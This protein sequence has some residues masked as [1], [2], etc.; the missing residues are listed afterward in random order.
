[1][2]EA[3]RDEAAMTPQQAKFAGRAGQSAFELYRELAVGKGSVSFLVWYELLTLCASGLPGIVGLGLRSL[4][5]PTMLGT[6][7]SGPAIGRGVVIRNPRKIHLGKRVLVDDYAV[8]DVRG[9]TGALNLLDHVSI[10]RFTTFAAKDG[11]ITLGAACN[12]G[13]YCRIA[14][15]SKIEFGESVL[16]GA[17]TYIVPGNHQSGDDD[18]PLIERDMEIKVGVTIGSHAWK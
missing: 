8:L 13:S 10:G 15:Q 2:S 6:S 14:T 12:I 18:R 7:K 4:L 17:Y 5:Y 3:A 11:S 9:E 16:F 1:M